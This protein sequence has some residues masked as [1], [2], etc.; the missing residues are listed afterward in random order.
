VVVALSF[1]LLLTGVA[2]AGTPVR[3]VDR[4]GWEDEPAGS[5]GYLAWGQ[6]GPHGTYRT[7]VKPDGEPRIQLNRPAT[8]SGL[9]VGMDGTTAVFDFR[10]P[11]GDLDLRMFDVLTETRSR[12]PVGINTDGDEA[13]PSLSGDWL[14]FDRVTLRPA[15]PARARVRVI[16]FN[17]STN[18]ERVLADLRSANHWLQASQVNGDWATYESCDHRGRFSNCQ[19][20]LYRISTDTTT[21][22]PNPGRQQ[23][24][25]SVT[26]DGTVYFG[27]MAGADYWICGRN[28]QIIR[29]PYGGSA[30]VIATFPDGWELFSSFALE[31]TDG[32]T[33]LLLGRGSCSRCLSVGGIW[34]IAN[35]DTVT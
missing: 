1:A 22:I 34:E 17:T 16:L 6:V 9:G 19:V 20:F 15:R 32:S 23:G 28:T 5:P 26:S 8:P 14:L 29:L 21:P 35:A 12:P 24:N 11:R 27:R 33:T 7:F 30:E 31:E 3:V 4:R 2:L 18:E 13:R 10:S 25:T